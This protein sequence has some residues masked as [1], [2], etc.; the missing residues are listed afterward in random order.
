MNCHVPCPTIGDYAYTLVVDVA[1]SS[2]ICLTMINPIGALAGAAFG[3]AYWAVSHTF[4]LI[5]VNLL[6]RIPI[7]HFLADLGKLVLMIAAVFLATSAVMMAGLLVAGVTIT[8]TATAAICLN[9]W[10]LSGIIGNT[11]HPLL[12]LCGAVTEESKAEFFM[13]SK[14]NGSDRP[15]GHEFADFR[16]A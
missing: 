13:F 3:V 10:A 5:A 1:V 14:L 12:E 7:D 11:F 9:I 16:H 8:F 4:R 15:I 6:N 2:V